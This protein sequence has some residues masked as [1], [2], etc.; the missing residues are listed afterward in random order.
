M[1]CV[2]GLELTCWFGFVYDSLIRV[3]L[4]SSCASAF[5]QGYLTR[6]QEPIVF[7]NYVVLIELEEIRVGSV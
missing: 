6:F 3:L 4:A 1:K 5:I 2:Y 7:Y